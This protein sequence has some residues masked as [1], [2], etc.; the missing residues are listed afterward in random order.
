[1]KRVLVEEVQTRLEGEGK[2]RD[3]LN[4]WCSGKQEWVSFCSQQGSEFTLQ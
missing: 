4:S 2:L 3:Q 1:M